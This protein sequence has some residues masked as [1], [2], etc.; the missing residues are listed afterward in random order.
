MRVARSVRPA[1]H[2]FGNGLLAQRA[3][4]PRFVVQRFGQARGFGRQILQRYSYLQAAKK[5]WSGPWCRS[6]LRSWGC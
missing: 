4:P 3:L 2:H 1:Y 6:Y 5:A